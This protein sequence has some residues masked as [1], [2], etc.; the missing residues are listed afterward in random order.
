MTP[1]TLQRP[2]VEGQRFPLAVL[3]RGQFPDVYAG[4][5]RPAW[6]PP[7]AQ[8][9]APAPTP[10]TNE[11]L[12]DPQPAPGKLLLVGNAQ[13]FHRNFLSGGHADFFLNSVDA[14]TLGGRLGERTQQEAHQPQHQQAQHGGAAVLAGDEPGAGESGHRGHRRRRRS[15][16]AGGRGRPIR[17]RRRLEKQV[18]SPSPLVGEGR[19]EGGGRGQGIRRKPPPLP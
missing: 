10:P 15:H 17:R 5:E 4:V 7:P 18:V 2:D 6:E 13:M 12:G 14:L 9:G 3:A 16:P 19:G 1:E 11:P 8:P